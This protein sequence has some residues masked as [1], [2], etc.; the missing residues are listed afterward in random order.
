MILKLFSDIDLDHVKRDLRMLMK[1]GMFQKHY[2]FEISL[3]YKLIHE[4]S[5]YEEYQWSLY[6]LSKYE[7]ERELKNLLISISRLDERLT[8]DCLS[9]FERYKKVIE[10]RNKINKKYMR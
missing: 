3:I 10:V 8:W 4:Y 6:T 9:V 2:S 7:V 5:N 1:K